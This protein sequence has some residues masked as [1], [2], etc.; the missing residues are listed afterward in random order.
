[1]GYCMTVSKLQLINHPCLGDCRSHSGSLYITNAKM[2]DLVCCKP[3]QE[4]PKFF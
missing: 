3:F 1:M 4:V 2:I